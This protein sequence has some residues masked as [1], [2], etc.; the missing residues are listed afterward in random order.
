MFTE[1]KLTILCVYIL[2]CLGV[3]CI[4]AVKSLLLTRWG[5]QL[6]QEGC[7]TNQPPC[8][9]FK[10]HIRIIYDINIEKQQFILECFTTVMTL[11]MRAGMWK[12]YTSP[13]SVWEH[14]SNVIPVYR[15]GRL[16]NSSM[17]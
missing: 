8:K 3:T 13:L 4:D 12:C 2:Y 10:L 17:N 15:Q 1:T 11:E 6:W 9:R 7:P 5:Q 16:L 14:G